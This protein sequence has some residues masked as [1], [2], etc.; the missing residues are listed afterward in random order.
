MFGGLFDRSAMAEYRQAVFVSTSGPRG[1]YTLH[2]QRPMIPT[3]H[4][5]HYG[6]NGGRMVPYNGSLVRFTQFYARG[7]PRYGEIVRAA[8]ITHL[9]PTNLTEVYNVS[10]VVTLPADMWPE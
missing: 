4:G 7:D 5:S 6:R 8:L 9:S 1:P 3:F 10:W 2:P